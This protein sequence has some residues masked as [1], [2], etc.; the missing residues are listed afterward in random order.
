M[1]TAD[2]YEFSAFDE[3]Q[4]LRQGFTVPPL[5]QR[6]C[7][8]VLTH[9]H[10][11]RFR[12]MDFLINKRQN[13][14]SSGRRLFGSV[15]TRHVG[16]ILSAK[17]EKAG[18]RYGCLQIIALFN[19]SAVSSAGASSASAPRSIAASSDSGRRARIERLTRLLSKSIA[20][21]LA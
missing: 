16:I 20:V 9:R 14:S 18:N 19:Y 21:I 17:C 11:R 8:A 6:Q 15:R 5:N 13:S 7:A 3:L 1:H 2:C 4:P 10:T 12:S